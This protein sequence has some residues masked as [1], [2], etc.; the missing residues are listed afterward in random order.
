MRPKRPLLQS[1][2]KNEHVAVVSAVLSGIL[3]ACAEAAHAKGEQTKKK[4]N[5]QSGPGNDK[6]RGL[7]ISERHTNG[8]S[9]ESRRLRGLALF[10]AVRFA[11]MFCLVARGQGKWALAIFP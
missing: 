5:E 7:R 11:G 2:I 8:R 4:R 10:P 3:G 1:R 6:N 9:G